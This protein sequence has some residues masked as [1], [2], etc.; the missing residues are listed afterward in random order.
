MLVIIGLHQLVPPKVVGIVVDGLTV[1]PFPTGQILMWFATIVLIAVVVYLLRYVWRVLLFGSSY[2]LAVELS[3]HYYR[4]LRRQHPEFCLRHPPVDLMSLPTYIP[5]RGV[6]SRAKCGL[7]VVD[8][9][10]LRF[11]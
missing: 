4:Q 6:F 2:Q 3:E 11:C 1:K 9:P 5:N 10:V 7:A 8:P